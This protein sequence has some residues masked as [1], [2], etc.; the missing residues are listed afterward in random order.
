LNGEEK[1]VGV[2]NNFNVTSLH[3]PAGPFV[4]NMKENP[5]EIL[6]FINYLVVKYQQGKEKE[7][8]AY[9]SDKWQEYEKAKP[10]EY[11]F[12]AKELNKLYKDENNVASLSL[13]FTFIIV[14]IASMGLFGLTSFMAEQKT[15]EIGIRKALGASTA[16]LVKMMSKEFFLL[17]VLSTIIAWPVAYLI[18]SNWLDHFAY[19]VQINWGVFILSGLVALLLAF[20]ITATKALAVSAINPSETLKYE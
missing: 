18:I 7:V 14:L 5:R 2:T 6:Y 16:S 13:V 8:I 20:T 9:I 15:R 17:I 10:F 11:S 1:V 3:E 4:I 12:L 19:R